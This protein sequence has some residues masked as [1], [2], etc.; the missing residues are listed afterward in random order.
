MIVSSLAEIKTALLRSDMRDPKQ[1]ARLL[2]GKNCGL[3]GYK[4]CEAMATAALTD[5]EVLKRCVYLAEHA[6]EPVALATE[7]TE[8]TWQDLLDREFD[9]VL[10]KFT[11][12]PGPR[13]H[14]LLA[15]PANLEKLN[16]KK[17]DIL[18]G[19]P[20]PGVGCPVTHCGVVMEEPDHFNGALVWCIVGPMLARER[21]IEIGYYHILA[22]EGMVKKSR[23][24]LDVG[25]RYFFLPRYCML[26][27]RHSGLLNTLAKRGDGYHVR[28]EGI[29]LG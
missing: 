5:P 19:R 13:E 24:Q 10:D 7:D 2:P 9:F 28:L 18:F 20:V 12:D 15:N 1:I 14:I 16:I 27:S 8:I 17:G 11:D 21:G 26:Q 6:A 4:N 22:Y 29:W 25:R 3:C 23:V